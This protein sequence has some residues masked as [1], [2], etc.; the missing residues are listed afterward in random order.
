[1]RKK[2]K[3]LVEKDFF[4]LFK[5]VIFGKKTLQNFRKRQRVE[6]VSKNQQRKTKKKTIASPAFTI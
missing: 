3:N 1:M 5:N 2:A 6:L 4:K